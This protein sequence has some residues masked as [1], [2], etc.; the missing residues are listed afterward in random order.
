MFSV[1]P[2]GI[3][4]LPSNF[5]MNQF[6]QFSQSSITHS[7]ETPSDE[8]NQCEL[9]F[10]ATAT[11][12]CV[13]CEQHICG[14][15]STIHRNQRVSKSHQLVSMKNKPSGE[16]R[17][18]MAVDYCEQHPEEQIKLYCYDCKTVTCL[19]CYVEKHNKHECVDVKKSVVRFS[20]QLQRDID[21]M[22]ICVSDSRDEL[23]ELKIRKKSIIEDVLV[24]Q[25]MIA[26]KC[27][28]LIALV[29]SH[30]AELME[31]LNSFKDKQLKEMSSRIADVE[32]QFVIGDSLMRYSQ[33]L[34]DEGTPSEISRA[35]YS[36]HDRADELAKTLEEEG[37]RE[38]RR[39]LITFRP[40]P[41]T[42]GDVKSLI[43]E[44]SFKGQFCFICFLC[45][46]IIVECLVLAFV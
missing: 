12:Y 20:E 30:E 33:K 44:L 3:Q 2:G 43:G 36:V 31:E 41:L 38:L 34:K 13:E 18:K 25:K 32:R 7:T 14:R 45:M 24:T 9:C 27:N 15:C 10:E 29:Q 37:F 11:T 35:A 42:T 28:Q 39:T 22:K 17:S 26:N 23:E 6:M 46:P 21:Q 8:V 5:F 19:M 40:S 1:P 16:G 4:Y